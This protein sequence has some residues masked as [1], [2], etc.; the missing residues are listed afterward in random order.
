MKKAL[1]YVPITLKKK[2]KNEARKGLL[3]KIGAI[4]MLKFSM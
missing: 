4:M 1:F 3:L 2:K